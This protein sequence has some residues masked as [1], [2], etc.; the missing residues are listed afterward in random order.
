MNKYL[1]SLLLLLSITDL[2]SSKLDR[3]IQMWHLEARR[4]IFQ[5]RQN[6]YFVSSLGLSILVGEYEKLM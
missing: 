5:S 4:N 6:L 2:Q 1:F 3:A